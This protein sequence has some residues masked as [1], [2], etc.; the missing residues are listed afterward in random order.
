LAKPLSP[1]SGLVVKKDSVTDVVNYIAA[2]PL[3]ST[4][5]VLCPLYPHND[6]TIKEELAVLLQKG[7]S[8]VSIKNEIK[9]VEDL[10]DDESLKNISLDE[11]HQLLILIDRIVTNEEEETLSRVADSIQT[12]FFE[13]K[14]DCYVDFKWR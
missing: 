11:N 9:K 7:F 3:E 14:G 1:I 10:L 6:R 12:A 5:T 2:L 4:V 13:G 8:R